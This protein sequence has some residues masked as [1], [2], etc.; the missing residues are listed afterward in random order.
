MIPTD[1]A[2]RLRL[3]AESIVNPVSP[4]RGVTSDLP[5]LPVGHRF[6]ARVENALPDGTFR[7]LVAGRSLTLSLPQPAKSGDT[8]DL[9]VTARTPSLII[10]ESADESAARQPSPT[11][12]SRAGQLISTLL[13][14]DKNAPQPAT[15]TRSAPLLPEPT[16]QAAR[17][18]P[19]LQQLVVDSGLFYES[20]QAQ[21]VAGRYPAEALA[22][23]PQARHVRPQRA[24]DV[25]FV[26]NPTEDATETALPK[27]S[28]PVAARG[29]FTAATGLPAELQSL[30]QQQL[31]AAATQHIVWRGEVWP[32]QALHW[33]IAAD[34]QQREN[35][36][37][38]TAEQWTTSLGLT[39]PRLG[40]VNVVLRL[41]PAKVSL[42]MTASTGVTALQQGLAELAASFEAAGLPPL[43][44]VLDSHE[45]A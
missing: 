25:A 22:R 39:L 5:E 11:T 32:G 10:A 17:L 23:E 4:V 43:S 21:W 28:E 16:L 27:G 18:A 9:V 15:I 12:L 26:A 3:M 8:L 14:G 6:T 30:V 1:L 20:H 35:S 36:G 13:S 44:A 38:E 40:E 31:D 33:E 19:A 29:A 24:P 2:A 7:A 37:E 34:E 45:P 42:H 41:A